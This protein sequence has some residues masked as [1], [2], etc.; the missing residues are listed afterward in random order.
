[1]EHRIAGEL[2]QLRREI[3][4][5]R[6]CPLADISPRVVFGEGNPCAI[7]AIV[8]EGPGER[9]E[10]EGR[11]FVGRAGALLNTLLAAVGLRRE[12]LWITNVLKRRAVK[13]VEG[14]ATNRPP[15]AGEVAVYKEYL[16]RELRTISPAIVLCLGSQAASALIHPNFQ[17][18]K[19]HGIWFTSPEGRKMMATFHPAYLLRLKGDRREEVLRQTMDDFA[20]AAKEYRALSRGEAMEPRKRSLVGGRARPSVGASS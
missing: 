8:G 14:K 1:M 18:T 12:E 2:Q 6:N 20:A 11:P 9:E 5:C 16:E 13:M 4:E 19:E 10:E 15:T 7:M 17:M 3:E